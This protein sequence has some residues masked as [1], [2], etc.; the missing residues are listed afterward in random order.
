MLNQAAE[1][2]L[3]SLPKTRAQ[4]IPAE[5]SDKQAL[6]ARSCHVKSMSLALHGGAIAAYQVLIRV[7]DR[8]CMQGMSRHWYRR[9]QSLLATLL[10]STLT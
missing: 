10:F 7:K 6:S 4:T 2:D 3:M 1:C 9:K 8:A 5:N